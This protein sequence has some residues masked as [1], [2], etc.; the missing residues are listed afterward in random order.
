MKVDDVWLA[1]WHV[2]YHDFFQWKQTVIV[3]GR[4]ES[5]EEKEKEH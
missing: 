2:R 4:F 3:V 1:Q 5:E